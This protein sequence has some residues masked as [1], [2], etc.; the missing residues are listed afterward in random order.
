MAC[1]NGNLRVAQTLIDSGAVVDART[2]SGATPLLMA[3]TGSQNSTADE[4]AILDV[5]GMLIARGA[6]VDAAN[7]DGWTPLYATCV[8][9]LLA[10]AASLLAS[11]ASPVV[12]ANDGVG[13]RDAALARGH[14]EIAALL[15]AAAAALV[16]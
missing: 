16:A 8:D 11:G 5:V 6:A 10:L 15:D 4:S 7:D 1:A 12:V 14:P 13:I 3:C 9:G 2:L